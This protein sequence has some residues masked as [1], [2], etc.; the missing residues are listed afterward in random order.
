MDIRRRNMFSEA[1]SRAIK[2]PTMVLWTS[3]DPTATPEE[4]RKI[5]EMIP[6]A[7]FVVMNECGHWPQF[8]DHALF[9]KLHL[10]FLLGR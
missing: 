5:S 2:A 8:E 10:D 7:K 3:H 1:Q 4:G 6:G 9:D